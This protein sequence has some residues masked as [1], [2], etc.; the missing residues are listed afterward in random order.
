[1]FPERLIETFDLLYHAS[2]VEHQS[3]QE[4]DCLTALL[5]K[6]FGSDQTEHILHR[7]N[8]HG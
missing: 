7:V 5:K 8:S 6:I 1:M 4:K 3:I 2:F